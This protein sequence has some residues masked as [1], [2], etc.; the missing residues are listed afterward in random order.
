MRR[1]QHRRFDDRVV[2]ITGAAGALG[3]ALTRR[4]LASGA[5]IAA[6]DLDADGLARLADEAREPAQR[7]WTRTCDV[8]DA[9]ACEAA[10]EAAAAH[11][12][13]LDVVVINAGITHVGPFAPEQL[14]THQRVMTIN[15][16][17]A[18][19]VVAASLAH[20]RRTRGA[21]VAVASVA[22]FAPLRYRTAYAAAKHAMV[23]FFGSLASEVADDGI[24][25]TIAC[26]TFLAAPDPGGPTATPDRPGRAG[27]TTG[28]P[29]PPAQAAAAIIAATARRRRYAPVGKLARRAWRLWRLAPR[30]YVALMRARIAPPDV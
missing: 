4:W 11:F 10:I 23:G 15:Y 20:L 22:G 26:P 6:L 7:L 30:G 28:K 14:P 9:A 13:R 19:H 18:V 3:T 25:V 24:D 29:L 1:M 12:G 2:L 8:T 21:Y 5:R 16:W 27:A 17:G